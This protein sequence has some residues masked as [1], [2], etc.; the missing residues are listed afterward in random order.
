MMA[1][2]EEPLP[3]SNPGDPSSGI[4]S[5]DVLSSL[6][7]SCAGDASRQ[8]ISGITPT[9]SNHG[10]E[11]DP[12][13]EKSPSIQDLAA[14]DAGNDLY[15]D[16]SIGLSLEQHSERSSSEFDL[17]NE[18]SRDKSDYG[19]SILG[20]WHNFRGRPIDDVKTME[21]NRQ[22][23]HTAVWLEKWNHQEVRHVG[24]RGV[25]KMFVARP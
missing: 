14:G 16:E 21:F 3:L 6:S 13:Q 4:H 7:G 24:L 10:N 22:L 11:A 5:T 15:P 23:D 18:T 1:L 19:L 2:V 17:T 25:F 12:N 20:D 9:D 8:S